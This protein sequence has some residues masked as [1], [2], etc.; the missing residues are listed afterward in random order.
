MRSSDRKGRFVGGFLRRVINIA[1][2]TKASMSN[3]FKATPAVR[4]HRVCLSVHHGAASHGSFFSVRSQNFAVRPHLPAAA[5][6][7]LP[8]AE[9]PRAERESLTHL[10]LEGTPEQHPPAASTQGHPKTH[11]TSE[12][13]VQTI[14][15]LCQEGC[16]KLLPLLHLTQHV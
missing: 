14:P 1:S 4:M 8:A 3:A 15:E 12:S 6:P 2:V 11:H 7:L 10:G 5:R 13:V 9:P 16:A